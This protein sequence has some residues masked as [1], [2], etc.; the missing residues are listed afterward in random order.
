M[1]KGHLHP[2]FREFVEIARKKL[3]PARFHH[4]LGFCHTA[5]ALAS[6][7]G[8][9]ASAAAVVGILHDL[10]KEN[11]TREI[12]TYIESHGHAI[13]TEDEPF[14]RVWHAHAAAVIAE[15]DL[16]VSD[17]EILEAI[18]LHSTA[19]AGVSMLTRISFV[20]DLIE[21]MRTWQEAHAIRCLARHDF[22]AAFQSAMRAKIDHLIEREKVVH[23]RALRALEAFAPRDEILIKEETYGQV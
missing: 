15:K 13:E 17:P 23:P 8:E 12:R 6:R 16:G 18:R 11:P 3:S 22:D 10:A 14:D 5:M 21:P 7:W 20:A 9:S 4:S 19:D 2:P 1:T